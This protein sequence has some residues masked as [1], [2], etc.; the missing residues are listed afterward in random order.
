MAK[1][2][3]VKMQFRAVDKL[4]KTVDKLKGKFGGI[5]KSIQKTNNNFRVMQARTAGLRK[6]F[7][8]A[9]KK[10]RQTGRSMTM[11]LSAPIAAFGAL[12]IRSAIRFETS[13][14]KV[15]AL[16][17]ASGKELLSMRGMAKDLGATT[18][19]SA[20]EAADA[21]AF[22]GMAGFSTNKILAATPQIL[23]LA[24]ASST[25]LARAAD[26]ASNIMGA[27]GLKAKD[28]GRISDVLAA[29]TA[30]ANVDME[31]LAE[32]MSKAAP[33]AKQ[34][35]LS[36]EETSA[37]V[38]LL[39]NVGIQGSVAGTALNNMML[40][41]SG[42][43]KKVKEIMGALS[44]DV[45]D[46]SG[47]MRK[48]TDILKD[49]G[50][51][52]G[53]LP[54]A[55]QL[56]ALNVVFGKRAIAGAGELVTQA[57]KVGTDGVNSIERFTNSLKN[58]SGEAE[59]MA[60][61]MMKG[62][63]GAVKNLA[64]AFEGLQIAIAESGILEMFTNFAK[65][66]TSITRAMSKASPGLIKMVA[67]GA[68]I[69]AAL[70]PV[71]VVFGAISSGIASMITLFTLIG[72]PIMAFVGGLGILAKVGAIIIGGLKLMGLGLLV[73]LSPIGL[74]VTAVVGLTA[75]LANLFLRWEKIKAGFSKGF[76]TGLKTFFGFGGDEDE[77]E[78]AR[79]DKLGSLGTT[80]GESLGSRAVTKKSI[81]Y[82]TRQQKAQ[83]DVRFANM[84]KDTR[85]TTE[86]KD[87]ILGFDSGIMGAF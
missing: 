85:V 32:T 29:T 66:L 40:N 78:K 48:M 34:Y 20:S 43:S 12:A 39:G 57:L 76:G 75:A 41:L 71:I 50:K 7:D 26:I 10:M 74:V 82:V 19:F 64:S 68:M 51:G 72:P 2:L 25:D 5:N 54:Q 33:I 21:M 56:A 18:Q 27:F 65:K 15:Q 22:L 70:G 11:G 16:T 67:I 6:G 52:L 23:N 86:D 13:M 58:S 4:S 84:P 80:S 61:V 9:G 73:M 35:G 36:I 24:A 1:D 3:P 46:S 14:N 42:G 87:N 8:N 17:K 81:D 47:K 59:R 79:G 37:A 77:K 83:V 30:S 63:P 28:M 31:M 62:A 38:G 45:V 55:K 60:K 44:T 53:D 49:M 69:V